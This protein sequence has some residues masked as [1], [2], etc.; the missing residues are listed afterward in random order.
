V[1]KINVALIDGDQEFLK[2]MAMYL[3]RS[4][5]ILVAGTASTKEQALKLP[6][7]YDIDIILTD[8]VLSG[9]N[10]EGIIVANQIHTNYLQ[11]IKII[12]LTA[13]NNKEF[14]Q[15]AF[16]AGAVYYVLKTNFKVLPTIIRNIYNDNFPVETVIRDYADFMK[17]K[18]LK[19]KYMLSDTETLIYKLVE[20]G[21]TQSAIIEQLYIS[22]STYK[23]H[24]NNILKKFN[25]TRMKKAIERF[26]KTVLS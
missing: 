7:I 23:K 3:N 2:N 26:N 4:E 21:N 13:Y 20:K 16:L 17:N 19:A 10:C 22:E 8:I 5:D 14:I 9:N 11:E 18:L 25:E 1:T 6:E 15:K 24:V 12:M